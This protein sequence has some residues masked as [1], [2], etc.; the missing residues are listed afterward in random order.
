MALRQVA[1]ELACRSGLRIGLS[2]W[3]NSAVAGPAAA[4]QSCLRNYASGGPDLKYMK[5]HEWAK[6]EGDTATVGI[7]DHAQEAL[8]EV[9]YLELPDVGTEVT[10]GKPFAV[11]ESV[12]AA[13]DV[14]APVSGEVVD[15]N[16]ELAEESNLNKVNSDAFG[17]WFIKIKMTNP[18]DAKELLSAEE[19]EKTIAH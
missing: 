19:Y 9:V 3:T 4:L 2:N 18:A 16:T 17:S 6:I 10:K 13:S 1:R 14:Y 12:K 5:S 11:V 15:A 8:G 7:S